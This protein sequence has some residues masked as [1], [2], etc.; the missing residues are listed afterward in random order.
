MVSYSIYS[1]PQQLCEWRHFHKM[2]EPSPAE[3]SRQSAEGQ[4]STPHTQSSWPCS[5]HSW[6]T[7]PE[8]L[9]HT[10]TYPGPLPCGPHLLLCSV[11]YPDISVSPRTGQQ[12]AC[13]VHTHTVQASGCEVPA[14]GWLH[15]VGERMD[16]A[17]IGTSG[18]EYSVGVRLISPKFFLLF[19]STVLINFPYYSFEYAQLFFL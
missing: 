13:R 10:T 17:F 12:P 19:Y 16:V 14:L 6:S 3:D 11:Q 4:N 8:T 18:L 9:L 15:P 2:I 5:T 7:I 1:G